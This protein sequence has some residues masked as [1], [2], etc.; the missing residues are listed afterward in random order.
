MAEWNLTGALR[1][2]SA[3]LNSSVYVPNPDTW[4]G[5]ERTWGEG[6][7]VLSE[8]RPVFILG[9]RFYQEGDGTQYDDR[10]IPCRLVRTG[11]VITGKGRKGEWTV[12]TTSYKEITGIW[13]VIRGERGTVVKIRVGAA[14]AADGEVLW[15]VERD[16][17]VGVDRFLDYMISGIFLAVSFRSEGQPPWELLSYELELS[18]V[19]QA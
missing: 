7:N 13:P 17:V 5:A 9:T 2:G 14:E 10:D 3:S 4:E 8:D 15:D 16:F 18:V 12:D 6:I 19:G 1:A 11:L